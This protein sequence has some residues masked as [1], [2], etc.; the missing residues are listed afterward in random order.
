MDEEDEHLDAIY[1]LLEARF[2]SGE[3]DVAARHN[4]H[5]PQDPYVEKAAAGPAEA[6]KK[7]AKDIKDPKDD[8]DLQETEGI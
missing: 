2:N 8:K 6:Q 1:A 5:Q 4:E 3:S 7:D